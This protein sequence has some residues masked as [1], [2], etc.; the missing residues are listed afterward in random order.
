M[1]RADPRRLRVYTRDPCPLC[2]DFLLE[3]RLFLDGCD[4]AGTTLE[5]CDVD[6]DPVAQRRFGLKVPVLL[7]DGE[8]V[9]HARFDAAGLARLLAR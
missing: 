5:V 7:L 3:L 4:P 9:A 1:T 6:A 8:P 2:D